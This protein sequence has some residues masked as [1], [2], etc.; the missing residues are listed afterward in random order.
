MKNLL[1]KVIIVT[2]LICSVQLTQGAG[3]KEKVA[4]FYFNELAYKKAL[5]Y[6]VELAESKSATDLIVRRTAEC[7]NKLGDSRNAAKWY[8]ILLQKNWMETDDKYEYALLLRKLAEY[9]QSV[10]LIQEYIREGGKEEYAKRIAE[11]PDFIKEYKRAATPSFKIVGNLPFNSEEHDFSPTF[12]QDKLVFASPMKRLNRR[13]FGA[14]ASPWDGTNFLQLYSVIVFSENSFSDPVEFSVNKKDRYH[15]GPVAFSPKGNEMYLTRSNYSSKGKLEKSGRGVVEVSLYTAKKQGDDT[16]GELEPFAHSSNE[17]STG[18]ATISADGNVMVFASDMPGGEGESDLWISTREGK[19]GW[20]EPRNL[21]EK[22]NST[23]RDNYPYLDQEGN[24]YYASEGKAGLGGFDIFWIPN[25]L[26]GNDEVLHMAAPINS[27]ADDFGFIYNSDE[28]TGFFNTGRAGVK[29]DKGADDIFS[30]E[31]LAFL[32]TVAIV[33]KETGEAIPEATVS[34]K[35]ANGELIEENILLDEKA[36]FKREL[37]ASDFVV[38]A[39]HPDYIAKS[40][41]ISI[42][43]GKFS[44]FSIGLELDLI[45]SAVEKCP[46]ITLDDIFYDF[47]EY[48]IKDAA[49]AALDDLVA[50]MKEYPQVKIRLESHT[51]S[52]GTHSYNKRL[53]QNRANSAADYL[54]QKGIDAD[55]ILSAEGFGETRLINNCSDGVACTRR[56][57]QANR[58]TEVIIVTEDCE[59]TTTKNKQ[60]D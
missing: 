42:T 18:S 50:F 49:S 47:D 53:S 22:I 12:Y 31:R 44:S 56:A 9:D 7:Y 8:Q 59:E 20:S 34:I 14:T 16:W 17:Y 52:R 4:D 29:G 10:A 46:K 27:N 40:K 1:R 48:K 43:K 51:D 36:E 19:G 25:F 60:E 30:F 6:Y 58:R 39:N 41:E 54:E 26:G 32:T 35:T 11:N 15:D 3:I 55:R 21:G 13:A 5:S 24:L 2:L 45:T 33:D 28:A 23:K 37:E 57:H 38:T